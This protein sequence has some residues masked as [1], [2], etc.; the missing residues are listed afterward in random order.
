MKY[1]VVLSIAGALFLA[2][3]GDEPGELPGP[4][5]GMEDIALGT[6]LSPGEDASEPVPECPLPGD[7][8]CT[9]RCVDVMTSMSHCGDCGNRCPTGESRCRNGVCECLGGKKHCG[10]DCVDVNTS[11]RHCGDCGQRCEAL[12]LCVA[13][14]CYAGESDDGIIGDVLYYTNQARSMQQDCGGQLMLP[15]PP[16]LLNAQLNEASLVHSEDMA[17]NRFM[18][19]EGSDGSSPTQRARRANYQYGVGENV[20]VGYPE[21]Q[22]V[23]L[24][25]MNSPGHCLN[26]MSPDWREMGAGFAESDR[27]Y[28]TQ[29][30]GTG[31]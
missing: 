11:I 22:A 2:C 29:L 17:R 31:P 15:Q 8:Y 24:G 20:A 14:T 12:S 23:V 3:G 26:I 5:L 4:D 6:D 30:F 13:G 9:D 7:K 10:V 16:L 21:A 27:L 18:G 25:W 19:H 28:W 1:L